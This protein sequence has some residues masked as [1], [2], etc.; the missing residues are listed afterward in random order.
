MESSDKRIEKA[1]I[2]EFAHHGFAGARIDRIAGNAK[3]NKAMIYYHYKSK[4]KLYESI[5]SIYIEGVHGFINEIIPH[6]KADMNQIYSLISHLLD[7]LHDLGPEFIKILLGELAS[8]GKYIRK[9]IFP[10]LIKPLSSL[11]IGNIN[12]EIEQKKI[13]PVNPFYT[14]QL[15]IGSIIFFNVMKITLTCDHR[16]VDGAVGSAFLQTLK[17]FIEDPVRILI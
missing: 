2:T 7:Y 10:K 11:I 9:F 3:V 6:G 16:T 1:A 5:L 14:F 15:I 17:G 13:K 8:G 4:E 12:R